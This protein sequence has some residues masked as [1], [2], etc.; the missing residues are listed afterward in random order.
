MGTRLI[1][2]LSSAAVLALS[3]AGGKGK[4]LA[5][6]ARA[7]FP[8]PRG[9]IVATEAYRAYVAANDL[10]PAIDAALKHVTANDA[11]S[12]ERASGEIRAAFSAGKVPGEL[13][14][15]LRSAYADY[16]GA[17]V[18][19]RSSAT[20]EDLPEFSFAG[21]QDT[22]LNVI[23][24]EYLLAAVVD[25]WSSLWT[26]RAIGYRLRN[27]I[28]HADMALAVVVQEMVPSDVSGVLFTANPLTGQL[29]ESV[30][31]ATFG[32][33][34]ALVSGRVEPD[35]FVVDSASGHIAQRTVGAKRISTRARPGGGVENIPEA[36]SRRAGAH[37]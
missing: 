11:G 8:V 13:A 31:D 16:N 20:A 37:G 34:E 25:C 27:G 28:S 32:L 3:D 15:A 5:L 9:F 19:V 33:G 35:H 1:F 24:E 36:C 23:G 18:A 7:G 17:P 10:Q 2:D 22:Y 12:L 4:N 26:A 14:S 30:I 21:Q 6:L 29:G